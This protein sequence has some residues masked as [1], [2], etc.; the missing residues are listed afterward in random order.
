VAC[1]KKINSIAFRSA[2]NTERAEAAAATMQ[3][4]NTIEAKRDMTPQMQA[5]TAQHSTAQT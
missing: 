2:I 5:R 1:W 4:H 3:A